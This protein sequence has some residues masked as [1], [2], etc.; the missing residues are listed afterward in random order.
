MLIAHIHIFFVQIGTFLYTH[1]K[2][3]ALWKKSYWTCDEHHVWRRWYHIDAKIY[4]G[5]EYSM[6][7]VANSQ[8][9][10]KGIPFVS[11]LLCFGLKREE[12]IHAK[13]ERIQN[14]NMIF[15]YP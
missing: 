13:H 11:C 8:E 2:C 10:K 4:E 14:T 12:K 7:V 3:Y 5:R 1:I 6:W 15:N 9:E